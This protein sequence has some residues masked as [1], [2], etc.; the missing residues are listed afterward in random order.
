MPKK[1]E[2]HADFL[3]QYDPDPKLKV[4]YLFPSDWSERQKQKFR[5]LSA[6]D[7]QRIAQPGSGFAHWNNEE[8]R[9]A[10]IPTDALEE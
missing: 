5:A 10:Y 8:F 3:E 1:K 7:K 6:Q 4:A 2:R 9:V